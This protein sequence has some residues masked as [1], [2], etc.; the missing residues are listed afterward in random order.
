MFGS[1][2]NNSTI[3]IVSRVATSFIPSAD[4][5]FDLGRTDLRWNNLF[6]NRIASPLDLSFRA[7]NLSFEADVSVQIKAP[8]VT[9]TNSD[10]NIVTVTGGQLGINQSQPACSVHINAIDALKIPVGSSLQR[11]LSNARSGMIRW[12]T[13]LL[14]YEGYGNGNVWNGLGGERMTSV[15]GLTSMTVMA[16]DLTTNNN[17]VRFFTAGSQKLVI[18]QTGKLGVNTAVPKVSLHIADNDAIQIPVGSTAQRPLT[19]QQQ[20]MIRWNNQELRFEG[21][22]NG[23]VWNGLGGERIT[24]VDGLTYMTVQAD[25]RVTSNNQIRFFTGGWQQ[26]V[27]DPVG[28]LGINTSSPV[29]SLHVQNSDAILIPTGSSAQRPVAPRL[30]MIRYSTTRNKYEAYA[31]RSPFGAIINSWIGLGNL[32]NNATDTSYV[33]AYDSVSGNSLEELQFVT[34]SLLRMRVVSDG[35]VRIGGTAAAGSLAQLDVCQTG[36]S[37]AFPVLHLKQASVGASFA[38]LSGASALG[39]TT[40]NLVLNDSNVTAGKIQAF[41]R[42]DVVDA[43]GNVATQGYYMPLYTLT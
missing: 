24:S 6:I 1:P 23:Q 12:N 35:T 14:R 40:N 9:I 16:D 15:D 26:A 42:V 19:V 20:G 29:V 4:G 41:M 37:T 34:D 28:R 39:N 5:V 36:T 17:Q 25:D 8:L 21:Y 27:I 18:D 31:S 10:T 13:D 3:S 43:N 30:G 7:R 32:T 11:P 22:G 2:D 38:K 33:S